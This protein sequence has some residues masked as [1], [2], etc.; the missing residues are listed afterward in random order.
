L[1]TITRN[2]LGDHF[3]RRASHPEAAG[4]TD[5]YQQLQRISDLP[6]DP[7][8]ACGDFDPGASL[9]HRTL[10]LIRMEFEE[11]T[12]QAFRRTAIEGQ[13]AA[14]VASDLG[15]TA[16]AVRQAKYRVLRRLR[17]EMDEPSV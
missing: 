1:W 6:A 2:K 11:T 7:S 4:G 13:T 12:W 15:M 10:N 14:G 16:H 8:Q 9:L 5:A 3:R 17:S